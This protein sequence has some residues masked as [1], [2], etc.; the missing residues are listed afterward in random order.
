MDS[1]REALF[2]GQPYLYVSLLVAE[3]ILAAI[4]YERRSRRWALAL[5]A[6]LALCGVALMA[7]AFVDTDTEQI[8]SAIRRIADD[9][10]A[11][12][13]ESAQEYIDEEYGGFKGGRA[14][15]VAFCKIAVKT[16]GIKTVRLKGMEVEIL[17]RRA[18]LHMTTSVSF[19]HSQFGAGRTSLAWN[20]SWIKRPIGWRIY[21]AQTPQQIYGLP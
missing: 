21:R 12:S 11:G 4:W 5:I 20:I 14:A 2:E 10:E 1:L 3:L 15:A 19:D 17:G 6:P 13:A 7:D 9:I 18:T 16:Y 8:I